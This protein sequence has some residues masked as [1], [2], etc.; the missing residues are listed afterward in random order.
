MPPAMVLTEF[1][2]DQ[3]EAFD[4]DGFLVIEEGYIS[5]DQV[6]RMRER[7]DAVY[8]EG[9][10]T[11]IRPDEVNWVAGRDPDDRTR[12]ICNGWKADNALAAQVLSD[13]TGR[14][15]AQLLGHGGGR[16]PQDNCRGK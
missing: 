16:I 8:R 5:D 6:E 7:F 2:P 12:Q 4:R 11:G 9:Y 14:L 3:V 13:R 1:T 10:E 15:A